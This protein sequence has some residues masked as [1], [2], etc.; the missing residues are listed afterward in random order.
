MSSDPQIHTF[1]YAL[2]NIYF[3]IV[4]IFSKYGFSKFVVD[5]IGFH[6]VH[7]QH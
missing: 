5:S 7:Y 3:N 4:T 1:N 2:K 6:S